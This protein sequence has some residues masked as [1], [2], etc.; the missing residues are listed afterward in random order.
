LKSLRDNVIVFPGHGAGSACGKKIS[1]R[2]DTLSN[3]K[4][5]NYVFNENLQKEEF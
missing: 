4:K 3:Q 5:S 2:S 1:G